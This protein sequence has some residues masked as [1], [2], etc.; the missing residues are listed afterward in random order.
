MSIRTNTAMETSATG[1]DM[2]RSCEGYDVH[3]V[4]GD[5]GKVSDASNEPGRNSLVVDTGVRI[6]GKKRM[7]PAACVR[8]VDHTNRRIDVAQQML[9]AGLPAT[10]V[11]G[12]GPVTTDRKQ[13]LLI[14]HAPSLT[15]EARRGRPVRIRWINELVDANGRFLPHLLPV[16]P[17]CTGRTRR[18]ER[19]AET[20]GRSSTRRPRHTPAPCRW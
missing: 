17:R 14:H 11:W 2:Q 18:A 5:I 13:G 3:A 19:R 12:Y 7:I 1:L 10:T 9:P 20:R 16:D 15:I 8:S 6:F 4:D